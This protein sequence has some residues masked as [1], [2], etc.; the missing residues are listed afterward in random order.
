MVIA[1]LVDHYCS[2]LCDLHLDHYKP[3]LS[4]DLSQ[5]TG[6]GIHHPKASAILRQVLSSIGE[7]VTVTDSVIR[8]SACELGHGKAVQSQLLK[9]SVCF[10]FCVPVSKH[11]HSFVSDT[12]M[13][14]RFLVTRCIGGTL[15]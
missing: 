3:I 5:I 1:I 7:H 6:N 13:D 15:V 14:N 4:A 9:F 10:H 12:Q 8:T 11:D 2:A